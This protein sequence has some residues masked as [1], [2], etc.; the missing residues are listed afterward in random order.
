MTAVTERPRLNRLVL[1]R[2]AKRIVVL[3]IVLG[4]L[5]LA[6]SITVGIINGNRATKTAHKLDDY[7]A[8][9]ASAFRT[10]GDDSQACAG[11]L[12]CL[13]QADARLGDS[14]EHVRVEFDTLT[15]PPQTVTDAQQLRADLVDLINLARQLQAAP[16]G[17]YNQTLTQLQPLASRFDSAYVKVRQSLPA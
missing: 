1:S 5:S 17:S 15:F 10:F 8:E 13:H 12:A 6:G 3:F 2:P 11:Q 16:P 9:T 4:V 7:Y 14:L